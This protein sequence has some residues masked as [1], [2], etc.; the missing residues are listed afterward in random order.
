MLPHLLTEDTASERRDATDNCGGFG[1]IPSI[2]WVQYNRDWQSGQP[3]DIPS[4][5]QV[6]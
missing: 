4:I 3:E 2:I 6:L 5:S 1:S